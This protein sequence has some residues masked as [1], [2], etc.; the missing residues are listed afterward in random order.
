MLIAIMVKYVFEPLGLLLVG[1]RK[2]EAAPCLPLELFF[3]LLF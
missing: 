1:K 3:P 2:S